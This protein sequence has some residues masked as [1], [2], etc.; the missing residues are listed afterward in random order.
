MDGALKALGQF[1]AMTKLSQHV[2][3]IV[4]VWPGSKSVG[5]AYASKISATETN[6]LSMLKLVRGIKEAGI[7]SVS[8]LTHSVSRKLMM[9]K[10]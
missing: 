4:F 5:Y 6:Q 10:T 9:Y 1:L 2:Y 3:P 7:N 8:F